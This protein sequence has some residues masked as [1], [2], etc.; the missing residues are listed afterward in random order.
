[1]ETNEVVVHVKPQAVKVAIAAK[2]LDTSE[3]VV[4]NLIDCG[5]IRAMKMPKL[6]VSIKELERF[7]EFAT[8]KQLDLTMFGNEKFNK[9]EVNI[10]GIEDNLV[11]MKHFREG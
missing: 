8:E 4:R 2:I 7:I 5:Y 9:Q 10:I 3:R 1:M 6:T 11:Q